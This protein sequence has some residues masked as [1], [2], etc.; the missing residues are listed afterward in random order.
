MKGAA[1]ARIPRATYRL[2]FHAGFDFDAARAILPYLRRLGVSHVYASPLLR[3]R[4]G[5]TH[6]Y[7]VVD[8]SQINPE[9]GGMAGFERFS[10]ALHAHGLR[11][12]LDIVPNH[13]GIGADNAWWMD[14]LAHGEASAHAR[15]FD[16]DWT[17]GRLVL[18][19]LGRR[20]PGVL[21]DGELGVTV[22][23]DGG[24]SLHYFDH[25]FALGIEPACAPSEL[26]RG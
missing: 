6:G 19:T 12:L 11:L 18:P 22:D 15:W 7:D 1:F 10:D 23:D 16:I 5:S 20:L 21:E 13:M 14:V 4:P 25:R 2:Q 3:A 24:F 26:Y 9:L 8:C 17:R